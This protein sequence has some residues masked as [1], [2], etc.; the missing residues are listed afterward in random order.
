MKTKVLGI[1]A[2]VGA[3]A[4]TGVSIAGVSGI[5][6]NINAE[7]VSRSI[8]YAYG[9]N[10]KNLNE[11]VTADQGITNA[12]SGTTVRTKTTCSGTSY[13]FTNSN[14]YC[15]A[16]ATSTA[17]GTAQILIFAHIMNVTSVRA[18]YTVK[19][20]TAGNY[21]YRPSVCYYSAADC[22][23]LLRKMFGLELTVQPT[24]GLSTITRSLRLQL[25]S[26]LLLGAS[27]LS[28]VTTRLQETLQQRLH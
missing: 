15:E 14:Y 26:L 12:G 17:G 7:S 20:D 23:G 11:E 13:D 1:L 18:V 2:L 19:S 5:Q 10:Q 8:T 6:S 24:T 3:A 21:I 9:V 28:S 27:Q 16:K 25:A 22:T 4:V